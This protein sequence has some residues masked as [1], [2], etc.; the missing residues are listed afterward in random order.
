MFLSDGV[1]VINNPH[2]NKLF[3]F[4]KNDYTKY[5]IND[6]LFYLLEYINSNP[7]LSVSD[8]LN[9]FDG[10]EDIISFLFDAKIVSESK[11]QCKYQ[12]KKVCNINSARVFIECTDKCNLSCPHCYGGFG[13]RN[14]NFIKLENFRQLL[15]ECQKIG[16][17]E[18]DITGGEPFM[19]PEINSI[20]QLLYEYSM[21]TT[22]FS[23]LTVCNKDH[24]DRIISSGVK[25]V[26]TSIESYDSAIHNSFRGLDNALNKT[27]KN[28]KY[29]KDQGVEV[30]V[31][32]VL[33]KHN[34]EDAE[35]TIDFILSLSVPC[36]IDITTLEGRAKDMDFDIPKAISI[37]K[38]YN[39]GS[40]SNNCGFAKRMLFVSSDGNIYP[41][42]SVRTN[43]YLF[44]NINYNYDLYEAFSSI[45]DLLNGWQCN[46]SCNNPN[47]PGG[48]RARALSA[49]KKLKSHDPYYC[50][51]YGEE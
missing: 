33:G 38:K 18:V 49:N 51:I 2:E 44:G 3:V 50:M 46:T 31:N 5:E 4:C 19:H 7:Q 14:S 35:K 8:L 43:D 6:D 10:I 28:I 47:C 41:C 26:V 29:L 23:N 27:I 9:E 39:N 36:I 12:I 17:Y 37:L 30:K 42:P 40:I 1:S 34:I 45:L 15:E 24:L 20:L 32:L 25:T 13:R 11:P 48:C 22:L 16:V 21:L